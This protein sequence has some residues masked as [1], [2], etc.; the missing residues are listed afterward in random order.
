[1]Q[2]AC[3][4]SLAQPQRF[5]SRLGPFA[6]LRENDFYLGTRVL[7]KL[8]SIQAYFLENCVSTQILWFFRISISTSEY[9]KN[10]VYGDLADSAKINPL[11]RI[12]LG[13]ARLIPT[14]FSTL[15][16]CTR[17]KFWNTGLLNSETDRHQAKS[18]EEQNRHIFLSAY[19]QHPVQQLL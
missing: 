18:R 4:A 11:E 19:G 14:Q 6:R 2:T 5:H 12:F 7:I 8:F 13:T 10:T 9:L 3:V 15:S 1:M 16:G 17:R